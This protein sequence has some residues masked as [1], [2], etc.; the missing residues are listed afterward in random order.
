[1]CLDQ[2]DNT[3]GYNSEYER[4]DN[5]NHEAGSNVL[6]DLKTKSES[7]VYRNFLLNISQ[8]P[9]MLGTIVRL[10]K[11]SSFTSDDT[12]IIAKTLIILL[13]NSN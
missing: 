3:N 13:R 6:D 7:L 11:R 10:T 5:L 8:S 1:M 12:C 2:D 4:H 9:T